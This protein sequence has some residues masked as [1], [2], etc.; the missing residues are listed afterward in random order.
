M[1]GICLVYPADFNGVV[2]FGVVTNKEVAEVMSLKEDE[3]IYLSRR[4]NSSLV[5]TPTTIWGHFEV[6][7][8]QPKCVL[9][10]LDILQKQAVL[11]CTSTMCFNYPRYFRLLL[12]FANQKQKIKPVIKTFR[13]FRSI[14]DLCL[15]SWFSTKNKITT[16]NYNSFVR[17]LCF[18]DMYFCGFVDLVHWK[19][20][21]EYCQIFPRRERNFTSEAICSWVFEHYETVLHWLQPPGTKSRLLEQELTKG[22]AMLMFLPHDPR[23]STANSILQQVRGPVSERQTITHV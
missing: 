16:V 22:P 9:C 11:L 21:C 13:H 3:S 7:V 15:L 14:Y 5:S 2:H 23:V 10:L 18:G 6:F 20:S 19:Y 17:L 12:L 4:F 1:L 8:L